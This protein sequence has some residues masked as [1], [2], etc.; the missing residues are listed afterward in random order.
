MYLDPARPGVEDLIDQICSGVRSACTYAGAAHA[1]GVPRAGGRRRPVGGRVPRGTAAV[2]QLVTG[3][4]AGQAVGSL[5]TAST[6]SSPCS[7][8]PVIDGLLDGVLGVLRA[9]HHRVGAQVLHQR[10]AQPDHHQHE[11]QGRHDGDGLQAGRAR[12]LHRRAAS[13]RRRRRWR[14][15]RR[16]RSAGSARC[17]PRSDSEP[18]TIEAASAPDTKKIATRTITSTLAAVA[19][20]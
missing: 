8:T 6:K 5:S 18:I 14:R 20:G 17:A 9:H 3:V 1:G 16:S 19:S 13:P 4:A 2:D 7:V 15:P 12:R 10:D 11:R